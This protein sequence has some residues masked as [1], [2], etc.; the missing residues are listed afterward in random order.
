MSTPGYP[1]NPN[2]PF[3]SGPSSGPLPQG[4][5]YG[6]Q[7]GYGQQP[8]GQN[9]GYGQQ[10]YQQGLAQPGYPQSGYPSGGYQQP[11]PQAA[12]GQYPQ[13]Q[14]GGGYPGYGQPTKAARPGM[15][16]A[17]A[18]LAFVWGGLALFWSVI[19]L[20]AGSLFSAATS[21]VC[22]SGTYIDSETAAACDSVGGVGGFLIA[23][24]I[25]LILV[26]ALLIAGG[27]TAINGKNGQLLVIAC[28]LYAVLAIVGLIVSGAFGVAYL[29]GI[30][31]P[32]LIVVF[33]LNGNSRNWFRSVG[34]R[35]F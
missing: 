4:G 8:Y 2:D 7:P 35:T 17:A 12:Y 23:I 34:G 21:A 20:L 28:A 31:V 29:L 25:G 19:G 10:G 27:V 30:V 33:M 5:S 32:V 6:Q 11:N 26:A 16:T 14:Y 15:V 9:P 22:N 3:S 1:G 24:T 13:Q 18:V